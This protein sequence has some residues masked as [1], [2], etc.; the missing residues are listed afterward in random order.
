MDTDVFV[1]WKK[2]TRCYKCIMLCTDTYRKRGILGYL[3]I[4]E[5]DGTPEYVYDNPHCHHCNAEIEGVEKNEY[6]ETPYACNKICT[7]GAMK[8]TRR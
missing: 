5:Y 3:I 2:C 4:D 8:I 7:T 6:D 1:D